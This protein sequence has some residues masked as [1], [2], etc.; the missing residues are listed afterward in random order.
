MQK[1]LPAITSL[2]GKRE[3][4][5]TDDNVKESI[6]LIDA[7]KTHASPGLDKDLSR[8]KQDIQNGVIFKT[9]NVKVKKS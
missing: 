4:E 8:L 1:I 5:L 9:F 2:I 3:A 6:D 7:L